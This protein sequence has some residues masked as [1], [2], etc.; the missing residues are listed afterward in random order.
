MG[1]AGTVRM[2]K[3]ARSPQRAPWS[4]VTVREITETA[5]TPKATAMPSGTIFVSVPASENPWATAPGM[6]QG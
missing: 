3:A 1:K 2:A 6:S 4:L 5:A